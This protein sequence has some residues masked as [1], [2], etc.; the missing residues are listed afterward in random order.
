VSKKLREEYLI[1]LSGQCILVEPCCKT[2]EEKRYSQWLESKLEAVEKEKEELKCC[3][4]NVKPFISIDYPN[5]K[6]SIDMII[7]KLR[8]GE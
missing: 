6:K 4:N 1:W 7:D 8:K 3:L 5:V 2:E